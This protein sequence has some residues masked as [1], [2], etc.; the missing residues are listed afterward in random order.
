L[1]DEPLS[2]SS[3]WRFAKILAFSTTTF[4]F[5]MIVTPLAAIW[6]GRISALPPNLTEMAT[7]GLW[8]VLPAPALATL[9]SW[10]QGSILHSGKTRGI[11]EAVVVFLVIVTIILGVGIN[12][13]SITGLYVGLFAFTMAMLTQTF[14][15]WYRSRPAVAATYERDRAMLRQST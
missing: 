11:P 9:Q 13:Y 6:F 7:L 2:T 14:W 4:Q 8:L 10:Y 3:L 5:I 12:L 15:L 1:L